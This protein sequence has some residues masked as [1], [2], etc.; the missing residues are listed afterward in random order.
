MQKFSKNISKL[1]STTHKKNHILQP[2]WNHPKITI[3]VQQMQINQCDIRHQ[4]KKRQKT[5]DHLNR[6]RKT[7]DKIQHPIHFKNPYESGYKGNTSQYNKS[8]L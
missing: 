8:H 3:M 5:H 6:C 1:N 2:S 7:S 4:Q